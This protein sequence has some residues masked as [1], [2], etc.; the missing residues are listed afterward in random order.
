[1]EIPK[2]ILYLYPDA[3][4]LVDFIVKDDNDGKGAYIAEWNLIPPMPTDMELQAAWDTIQP[5]E[6]ELFDLYKQ[7]KI[8]LLDQQCNQAVLGTFIS[9]AMGSEHIYVFDIEAQIN[10]AGA[11]QAFQDALI[12]EID[13]NTRDAGVLIHSQAQF[14][15]LWLDGFLHKIST[16]GRFRTLLPLVEAAT[17]KSEVD[18]VVW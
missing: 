2:S 7:D 12:T 16:I 10:L 11:K 5:T 14:N 8:H 4:P 9:S 1:M 3:D 18:A 15:Q 6:S 13:W 17:T